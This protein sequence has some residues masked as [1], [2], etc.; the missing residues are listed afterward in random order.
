MSKCLWICTD[1][2]LIPFNATYCDFFFFRITAEFLQNAETPEWKNCG[3][4]PVSLATAPGPL[5]RLST[6]STDSSQLWRQGIWQCILLFRAMVCMFACTLL[7]HKAWDWPYLTSSHGMLVLTWY[8]CVNA[9]GAAQTLALHWRLLFSHCCQIGG[10]R[11]QRL[12][13]P[14]SHSH[15]P[16]QVHCVRP[17]SHG[18]DRRREAQCGASHCHSLNIPASL[19]SS[20]QIALH[21]QVNGSPLAHHKYLNAVC[22]EL[23]K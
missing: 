22:M 9:I 8:C 10:D 21:R 5:F 7:L 16:K 4:W 3:A 17:V 23:L 11:E 6:Y 20:L 14:W 15:Q 1:F 12:A 2:A 19:L 18:E 13:R